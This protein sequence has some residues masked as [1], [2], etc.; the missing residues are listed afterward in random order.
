MSTLTSAAFC[1]WIVGCTVHLLALFLFSIETFRDRPGYASFAAAPYLLYVFSAL[2]GIGY[3][4]FAGLY[5]AMS[6]LPNDWEWERTSTAIGFA[7][8]LPFFILDRMFN[9]AKEY[10]QMR[11]DLRYFRDIDR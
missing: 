3:C 5:A 1:V 8:A 10:Q 11:A 7:G 4:I 6:W 2:F 9:I